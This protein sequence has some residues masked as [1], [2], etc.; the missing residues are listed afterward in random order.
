MAK[1]SIRTKAPAGHVVPPLLTEVATWVKKQTHGSLGWF[2]A[3]GPEPISKHE[4][5][6]K[7][8][9]PH[10]FAFLSLPDGSVLSL[11]THSET[12]PA[13]VVLLDS[14]GPRKVV[15]NSLEDFLLRWSKRKTGIDDLDDPDDDY[16][17]DRAALDGWL[18]DKGVKA[19]K[20]T[21]LNFQKWV[22]ATE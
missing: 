13:A 18:K 3:F 6:A 11:I 10:G 9:R 5:D 20:A 14:E 19:P 12:S 22:D 8:L 2:D 21:K 17:D 15:A 7:R 16:E 4:P 1:Y